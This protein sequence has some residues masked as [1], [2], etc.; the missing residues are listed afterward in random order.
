LVALTASDGTI[1]VMGGDTGGNPIS[2]NEAFNPTSGAWSTRKAIP[3]A[4][5]AQIGGIDQY[6]RMY[7]VGGGAGPYSP[8]STVQMYVPASNTWSLAPPLLIAHQYEGV[9]SLPNGNLYAISGSTTSPGFTT[10][11]ERYAV[12]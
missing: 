9:A 5:E 8:M 7:L 4:T 3:V 2:L 10:D 11:V 6:G 1:L 12:P